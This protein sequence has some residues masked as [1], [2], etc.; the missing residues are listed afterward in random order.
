MRERFTYFPNVYFPHHE[1]GDY[2][3]PGFMMRIDRPS[4]RTIFEVGCCDAADT[5][6][7]RRAFPAVIHAFECNP[8]V[9][10]QTR[11]N[12]GNIDRIHLVERTVW[13]SEGLIPFF[14]VISS[15]L[16]GRPHENP[17]ASSCFKARFDYLAQYNLKETTVPAIRLDTYCAEQQITGVDLLCIDAQGAELRALQGLGELIKTVR[18]VIT[19]IEVQPIYHGQ[20][21]YPQVHA[22]LKSNGFYQAAEVYRDAWFSD[23]LYVRRNCNSGVGTDGVHCRQREFQ[24]LRADQ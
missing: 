10:P 13:D 9:L 4:V 23:Y 1:I 16:C 18:Y 2:L 20:A 8:D 24:D 12:V 14:P 3:H 15:V 17:G 7:L 21:L 19:E 11:K 6:R 22:Y 5:L